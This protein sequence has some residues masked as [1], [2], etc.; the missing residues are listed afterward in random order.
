LNFGR[1]FISVCMRNANT[2][3]Y[4]HIYGPRIYTDIYISLSCTY[5]HTYY[6][7]TVYKYLHLYIHI[8]VFIYIYRYTKFSALSPP[9]VFEW[10]LN[11]VPCF[12]DYNRSF[13]VLSFCLGWRIPNLITGLSGWWAPRSSL[14][15]YKTAR[16]YLPCP[17]SRPAH[18]TLDITRYFIVY[19]GENKRIK[20]QPK[21]NQLVINS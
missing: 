12:V 3:I 13:F 6:V 5:T 15:T 8:Y 18:H 9:V 17:S 14:R 16:G 10:V 19:S 2:Y 21:I 4:V 1:W 11:S 20:G 7:Y